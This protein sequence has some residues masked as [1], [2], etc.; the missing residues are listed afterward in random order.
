MLVV[1]GVWSA[2]E[3]VGKALSVVDKELGDAIVHRPPHAPLPLTATSLSGTEAIMS[4][5][6]VGSTARATELIMMK[7]ANAA[8]IRKETF[9]SVFLVSWF[10][11]NTSHGRA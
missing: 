8:Q 7:P 1:V 6:A 11:R 4:A 10:M 5:L 9:I 2:L 3:P